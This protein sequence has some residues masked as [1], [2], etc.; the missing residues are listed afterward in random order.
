MI[1][2]GVPRD[3]RIKFVE[4]LIGLLL[5]EGL[6]GITE[7]EYTGLGKM[8]REL[9]DSVTP[10]PETVEKNVSDEKPGGC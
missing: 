6:D 2:P 7:D 8:I 10:E 3:K 1:L 4:E 9:M 5:E